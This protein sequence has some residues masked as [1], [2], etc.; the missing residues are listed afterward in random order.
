MRRI[1][2]GGT[3]LS[4]RTRAAIFR[5]RARARG[6]RMHLEYRQLGHEG[7]AHLPACAARR[8][9]ARVRTRATEH[10]GPIAPPTVRNMRGEARGDRGRLRAARPR[11]AAGAG[12]NYRPNSRARARARAVRLRPPTDRRFPPSLSSARPLACPRKSP[13][14]THLAAEGGAERGR[15]LGEDARLRAGFEFC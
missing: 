14:R 9:V 5:A 10:G 1:S 15:D 6:G 3:V 2:R 8:S 11:C 7:F 4:A 13:G 12:K